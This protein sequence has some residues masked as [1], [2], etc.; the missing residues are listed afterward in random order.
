[1]R[2]PPNLCDCADTSATC[3]GRQPGKLCMANDKWYDMPCRRGECPGPFDPRCC[4]ERVQDAWMDEV[5][6]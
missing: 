2:Q 5:D 3:L 6:L 1:M 4:R